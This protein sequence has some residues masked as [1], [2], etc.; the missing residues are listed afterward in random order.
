MI[1]AWARLREERDARVANMTRE[2]GKTRHR[3]WGIAANVSLF[4]GLVMVL[5]AKPPTLVTTVVFFLIAITHSLESFW[6]GWL[7]RDDRDTHN[8]EAGEA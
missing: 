5:F 6:N 8:D 7:A 1:K 2:V 3:D 4:T